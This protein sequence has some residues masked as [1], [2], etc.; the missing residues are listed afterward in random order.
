M[1]YAASRIEDI[2]KF[3]AHQQ[4]KKLRNQEW[5]DT[6]ESLSLNCTTDGPKIIFGCA[7]QNTLLLGF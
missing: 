2:D 7:F 3:K 6:D 5:E 1:P 4:I